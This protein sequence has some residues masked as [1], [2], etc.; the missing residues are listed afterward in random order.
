[1]YRIDAKYVVDTEYIVYAKYTDDIRKRHNEE[2]YDTG[3][4]N[5]QAG[6][7]SK[8]GNHNPELS[9]TLDLQIRSRLRLPLSMKFS[10]SVFTLPAT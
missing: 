6:G 10:S 3:K 7:Q 9:L 4:R 1:V 5:D 2:M 8:A